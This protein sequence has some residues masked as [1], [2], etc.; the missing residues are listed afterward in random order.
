MLYGK[1]GLISPD[2]ESYVAPAIELAKYGTF[3]V[4]GIPETTRTPGYP[5]FLAMFI[6]L[7]QWEFF[8]VTAQCFITGLMATLTYKLA[9][10]LAGTRAACFA[11]LIFTASLL[12]VIYTSSILTERLASFFIAT[13]CMAIFKFLERPGVAPVLLAGAASVCAAF[14]RPAA[15]FMP[16]CVIVFIISCGIAKKINISRIE[17]FIVVFSIISIVPIKLWEHRNLAASGYKGFSSISAENLYFYN[18]AGVI[19]KLENKSFFDAQTELGYYDNEIY[20][21]KHP[22]QKGLSQGEVFNL[23]AEEGKEIIKN[24]LYIYSKVHLTGMLFAVITPGTNNLVRKSWVENAPGFRRIKHG[25]SM[26]SFIIALMKEMPLTFLAL[27]ASAI[28]LVFIY[29]L[30]AAGLAA[31]IKTHALE[32]TFLALTAAYFIIIAGGPA[33]TDRFRDPFS[34]IIAIWAGIG[35]EQ[36]KQ[37]IVKN[38]AQ[39]Q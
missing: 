39:N 16:Y 24:N 9:E 2:T 37:G 14:V 17:A 32:T 36:L 28:L 31:C 11:A 3:S 15:M 27:A 38:Y 25:R 7:P 18:A 13:L 21:A 10:S 8:V 19:A 20:K 35:V 30:S 26:P 22:E 6:T 4:D 12:T 33:A 23:M 1:S 5:L 29:L 34:F